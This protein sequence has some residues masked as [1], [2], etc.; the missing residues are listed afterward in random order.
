MLQMSPNC[1]IFVLQ[2]TASLRTSPKDKRLGT[3]NAL[4]IV[5][6]AAFETYFYV[7]LGLAFERSM[8]SS[9]RISLAGS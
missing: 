7:N 9:E 3:E 4:C 6:G 5:F 1:L 8:I 2:Q